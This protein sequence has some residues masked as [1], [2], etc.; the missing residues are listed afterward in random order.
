MDKTCKFDILL[1][2]EYLDGFMDPLE[3]IV[4]E[5]H[6]KICPECRREL[7]GLKL[8]LWELDST[9]NFNVE[10]PRELDD[11][12]DSIVEEAAGQP[13]RSTTERI[14]GMQLKAAKTSTAFLQYI[15][16]VTQGSQLIRD[17]VKS[18]LKSGVKAAPETLGKLGKVSQ[19]LYRG[20]KKLMS[21]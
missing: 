6:L 10:I 3:K 7:T 16:G 21:K 13:I 4:L 20:T 8:T 11:M 5:E 15:P 12:R 18:G 14:V 19:T 17:G 1:L 2:Q 9:L